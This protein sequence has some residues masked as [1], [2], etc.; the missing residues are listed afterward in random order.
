[1]LSLVI[2]VI[3]QTGV[4]PAALPRRGTF[5]STGLGA[6]RPGSQIAAVSQPFYSHT[7]DDAIIFC[8]VDIARLVS[9]VVKNRWME[10]RTK[11]IDD[12]MTRKRYKRPA[13][14]AS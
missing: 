9:D 13:T 5:G 10:L 8:T 14:S 12:A 11:A 3:S 6:E 4:E 2:T 7:R 1:M